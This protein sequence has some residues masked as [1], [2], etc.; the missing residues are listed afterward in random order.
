MLQPTIE[1]YVLWHPA[2]DRGGELMRCL[3]AHFHGSSYSGLLGHPIEVFARSQPW[4]VPDGAPRP[5]PLPG[6]QQ[7]TPVKPVDLTAVVVLAGTG[8][9]RAVE[10]NAGGWKDYV[11]GLRE[12]QAAWQGHV[13]LFPVRAEPYFGDAE[14]ALSQQLGVSQ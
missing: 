12:A 2:D 14:S 13:R 4:A 11:R 9:E 7:A 10:N 6:D 3:L 1:V 8:L 5:I